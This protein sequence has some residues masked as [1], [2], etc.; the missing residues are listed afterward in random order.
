MAER[1]ISIKG[2]YT[3]Y[4]TPSIMLGGNWPIENIIAPH[5][6]Y[7]KHRAS[8]K[9]EK[10][11]YLDH[12]IKQDKTNTSKLITWSEYKKRYRPTN[13]GKTPEWFKLIEKRTIL[14]NRTII[15]YV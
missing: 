4:W 10:I 2:E 12:L 13:K 15:N 14:Q 5:E 7:K 6:L 11:H 1:K 9:R 3:Q 8:L